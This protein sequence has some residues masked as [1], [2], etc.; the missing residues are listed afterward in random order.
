MTVESLLETVYCRFDE[1]VGLSDD[2]GLSILDVDG[3]WTL[4]LS[5]LSSDMPCTSLLA[6]IECLPRR[7]RIFPRGAFG[8]GGG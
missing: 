2:I 8:F 3:R 6:A 1:V 7:A 4:L 5:S